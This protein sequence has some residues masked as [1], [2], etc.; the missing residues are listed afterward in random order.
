MKHSDVKA[1]FFVALI[2]VTIVFIGLT[3][4]SVAEEET[5]TF[6]GRVVDEDGNPIAHSPIFMGPTTTDDFWWLTNRGGK[7][8]T[9]TSFPRDYFNLRRALTDTDGRFVIT[10]IPSGLMYFG[11]LPYNLNTF[12]PDGFKDD[13]EKEITKKDI[14]VFRTNGFFELQ[15]QDFIP[16]FQILSLRIQG[17]TFYDNFVFGVKP[18]THFKDV[19]VTVKHR[20]RIRGRVLFKD[21]TPIANARLNITG[22]I[23]NDNQKRRST[24]SLYPRTDADGYFVLYLSERNSG[25]T[26]TFTVRYQGLIVHANPIHANPIKLNP[27]ER[28]DGLTL[29]FDSEPIPS[30]TKTTKSNPRPAPKPLQKPMSTSLWIVNPENGH[31]YREVHCKTRDDA[32]AQA[33]EDKAHLV[34]INNEAEQKWLEAV[35]GNQFYWIGLNRLPTED[36]LSKRA[37]EWQWDNGELLTYENWLPED[38]FPESSD[39]DEKVYAVMTPPDGKWY[40]VSP[41]SFV[42]H[43]TSIALIEKTDVKIKQP[44]KKE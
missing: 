4:Y 28:L 5:S 1:Q 41:K 23:Q 7:I 12:L 37:K 13:I 17:I 14:D 16:D 27:G 34:T 39:A 15:E 11:A 21:R 33:A 32:V 9:L 44:S 3:I 10:G 19:V 40:A 6:S 8:R 35:F 31:A 43:I 30:K 38:F 36:A 24:F 26:Y 29:T 42:G 22:N 25:G 20:T 18:G 2:V